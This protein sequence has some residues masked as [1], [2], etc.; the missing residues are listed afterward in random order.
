[1]EAL[2]CK[3]NAVLLSISNEVS[4]PSLECIYTNNLELILVLT[5]RKT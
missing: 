3:D 2:N 1:M 5:C 4:Q